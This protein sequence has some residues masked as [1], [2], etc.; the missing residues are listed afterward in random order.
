MKNLIYIVVIILIIAGFFIWRNANQFDL[1]EG[2]TKILEEEDVEVN[3]VEPRS[4]GETEDS[5]LKENNKSIVR[6]SKREILITDGIKHSIPLDEI[7][8]GGPPKDG[9]PSIDSPKFISTSEADE[10]TDNDSVGLGFIHKGEARFYPYSI[11]VW[12]EIVNDTIMGDP[13][14]VTYCPLCATGV[15]FDRKVAGV[16]QEFGV[17]GRLW[18]SNLLMYN[19]SGS[20]KTESLWSQVLGEA[21]LG[22]NTGEKLNILL[23]DTV[24]YSEWKKDNP[25][26]LVLSQE[27]G[28]SR[29]YGR[30]PYGDYYSDKTVGFGATFNDERLHPKAFVLGIEIGEK[31][32]AYDKET[33]AEGET[34]DSFAGE[35]IRITRNSIGEVRMFI[36]E[37]ELPIIGGFWFSWLAVHPE[38][39]LLK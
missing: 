2:E 19:R 25:K 14:L 3:E 18:K 28:A 32:K 9:I 34:I 30:D 35:N 22:K 29:S 27:T 38:T 15:V 31:F 21:V 4:L 10:N 20:E 7:L 17:S 1:P 33:L 8:S 37:S 13:V 16:A 6:S 36:G 5:K 24:K 12:H 11:L 39:E 26:T 23:S